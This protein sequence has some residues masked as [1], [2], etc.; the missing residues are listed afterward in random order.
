MY[1]RPVAYAV[2]E[3]PAT[4]N[5]TVE[6]CDTASHSSLERKSRRFAGC[7]KTSAPP[8]TNAHS[9]RLWPTAIVQLSAQRPVAQLHSAKLSAIAGQRP[10]QPPHR[11]SSEKFARPSAAG[12]Q[13]PRMAE[14]TARKAYRPEH[15][16]PRPP[17]RPRRVAKSPR[18]KPECVEPDR[19]A[20]AKPRPV[21]RLF[22][23]VL[24]RARSPGHH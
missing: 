4:A 17:G 16:R 14:K 11:D 2:P 1:S 13:S 24:P 15:D 7:C 8:A 6:F 21:S 19:A 3:E 23:A 18:P 12:W 10:N 5:K 22:Y 9:I 20:R